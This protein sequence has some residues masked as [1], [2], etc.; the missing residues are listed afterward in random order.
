MSFSISVFFIKQ[1]LLVPLEVL[2]VRYQTLRSCKGK[3]KKN[4]VVYDTPRSCDSAEYVCIIHRGVVIPRCI[5]KF[6]NWIPRFIIRHGITT[7]Q[8]R[9]DASP[10]RN[11][12]ELIDTHR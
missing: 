2:K 10:S 1:L 12:A 4:L 11:T 3:T 7:P 9:Y 8:F 5:V 6:M